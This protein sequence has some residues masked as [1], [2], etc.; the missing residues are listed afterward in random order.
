MKYKIAAVFTAIMCMS[1]TGVS[2]YYIGETIDTVIYSS[3]DTY[4]NNYPIYAYHL[5]G[6]QLICAED[7]RDYGFT[8]DWSNE[9]RALYISRDMAVTDIT[10][11]T[12]IKQE[13]YLARRK[14]YDIVYSDIRVFLEGNETEGFC[15]DGQTMIPIRSLEVFGRCEYSGEQ[16]YSKAFIDGLPVGEYAPLEVSYDKKLTVVL[17]AGHGKSSWLM[18]D[19]EKTESGYYNENGAWLEWRHWKSGTVGEECMGYGCHGDGSCRYAMSGGDRNIEPDIDLK[20]TLAAKEYLEQ[21]GYNVRLT[22][23]TNEENPSFTK[24]VSYCFPDNDFTKEPDAACYI[25]VHSNAGGGRGTAYIAANGDYTQKWISSSYVKE[26]NRLGN[27]VNNSIAEKT[28]LT[29]HGNGR[30]DGLGYMI[31]FN[32]CPVPAGYLEI[33][34]F[35]SPDIDI[36][37]AEHDK[38]GKAIAEGVHEYMCDW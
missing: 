9:D 23:S 14:A 5:H 4:I 37:R 26:S 34:F 1:V 11:K 18:S 6:R 20:N 30:I 16:N 32:K 24:R 15:I 25:C 22:R 2:A 13:Y 19:S 31:L 36:I 17:D 28:S 33:G 21:L 29:K 3:I 10:P 8:V 38:I 35:D 27:Y 7:L 12:D